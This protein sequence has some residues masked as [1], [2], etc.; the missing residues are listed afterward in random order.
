MWFQLLLEN[1]KMCQE[2]LDKVG[3][4]ELLFLLKYLLLQK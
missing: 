2:N 4:K 3:T 1:I